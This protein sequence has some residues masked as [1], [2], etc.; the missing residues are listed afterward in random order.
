M[1]ACCLVLCVT[2][3]CASLAPMGGAQTGGNA[4][5][6]SVTVPARIAGVLL[7]KPYV[8]EG[9]TV[10][11]FSSIPRGVTV[12][13]PSGHELLTET[14]GRFVK[15]S[16][17]VENFSVF[18]DGREMAVIMPTSN[19]TRRVD[20]PS[21][22]HQP[23]FAALNVQTQ[24]H[25]LQAEVAKLKQQLAQ[26]AGTTTARR[27][28]NLGASSMDSASKPS[29]PADP[30]M[31]TPLVSTSQTVPPSHVVVFGLSKGA[32]RLVLGAR[33][34]S[35]LLESTK[36]YQ[37]VV[38]H[39][40]TSAGTATAASRRL[41]RDRAL[42]ARQFLLDHGMDASRIQTRFSASRQFA[43]S[44]RTP[45]GQARNRRVEFRF[46]MAKVPVPQN[47]SGAE[48][49]QPMQSLHSASFANEAPNIDASQE[50]SARAMRQC[51]RTA[52]AGRGAL[53]STTTL[54]GVIT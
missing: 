9:R 26:A 18:L 29:V 7:A 48:P 2:A 37:S 6:E 27:E 35:R 47:L 30:P 42:E 24:L 33:D 45:K 1:L 13:D 5:L 40:Y 52:Q 21:K 15:L 50:Q 12:R 49:K 17:I 14:S 41:A 51:H 54:R 16:G 25:H 28:A 4:V 23:S 20:P 11:E 36:H 31:L 19:S 22:S 43:V 10:L 46:L 39:A 8:F 53:F 34:R 44:N 32:K 38:I 3:G